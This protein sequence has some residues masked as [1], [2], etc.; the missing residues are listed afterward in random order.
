LDSKDIKNME[1]SELINALLKEQSK[2]T[3]LKTRQDIA[4]AITRAKTAQ[5]LLE[6]SEETLHVVIKRN[7]VPSTSQ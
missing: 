5:T 4:T 1:P 7:T 6:V 3:N 2:T